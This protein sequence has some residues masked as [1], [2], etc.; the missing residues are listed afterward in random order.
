MDE[1]STT[2]SFGQVPFTAEEQATVQAA[3]QQKLGPEYISQRTGAGG[4]KLAYIEGHRVIHLANET[5]G[6]NGWSHSITSETVDFIDQS[7]DKFYVGVSAFVRVQLK[8]GTYHEDVGYGVSEGMRSK[9]LSIEKARKEAVTDSLKRALRSFGNVLGNCISDKDYL[10]FIQG[11]PKPNITIASR[12]LKRVGETP[13]VQVAPAMHT[14]PPSSS[15]S[16][17]LCAA[18]NARPSTNSETPKHPGGYR[19][20]GPSSLLGRS[21]E[22]KLSLRTP[23]DTSGQSDHGLPTSI[24]HGFGPS[25]SSDMGHRPPLAKPCTDW[26]TNDKVTV[27]PCGVAVGACGVPAGSTSTVGVPAGSTPT[28]G[29]PAGS[30]S[31]VELAKL[32]R[33]TQQKVKKLEWLKRHKGKVYASEHGECQEECVQEDLITIDDPEFWEKII[34]SQEPTDSSDRSSAEELESKHKRPKTVQ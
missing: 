24:P 21:L 16:A 14:P 30:T 2:P 15:L 27:S 11:Q 9:A 8:D 22:A 4:Q 32:H 10:R 18:E 17:L 7:G 34:S 3:L 6:F 26:V 31:T 29:V 20:S 13:P 28:V 1:T 19:N 25:I 12:E 5:F 23:E 33:Q